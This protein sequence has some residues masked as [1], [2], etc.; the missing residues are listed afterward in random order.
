[1]LTRFSGSE[2][3]IL[4]STTATATTIIAARAKMMIRFFAERRRDVVGRRF[5]LFVQD[6]VN[7]PIHLRPVGEY[8]A[9]QRTI[10]SMDGEPELCFPTPAR[11]LGASE[12]RRD[13]FPGLEE[14]LVRH[15]PEPRRI[16]ESRTR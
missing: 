13:L 16:V 9:P 14:V 8:T 4:N 15:Q 6:L 5:F 3:T 7:P 11:P 12:V 1:M 2:R 10:H